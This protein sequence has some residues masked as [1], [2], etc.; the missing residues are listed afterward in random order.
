M[1][2][3][4]VSLMAIFFISA[5]TMSAQVIINEIM[6][7]PVRT[8]TDG[9]NNTDDSGEWIEF[10]NAG[11]SEVDMA[12]WSFT[13]GVEFTFPT[14]GSKIASGGYFILGRDS[15]QFNADNNFY[16]H[17]TWLT[18]GS[19]ALSNSGE[20]IRVVNASGVTVDSVD[21]DD[22]S[23]WP[24]EADGTGPSLELKDFAA[25]NAG[26][27]NSTGFWSISSNKGTPN[28]VNSNFNGT[29]WASTST[30]SGGPVRQHEAGSWAGNTLPAINSMDAA[31]TDKN[32]W[33]KFEWGVAGIFGTNDTLAGHYEVSQ[34][35]F[36]DSGYVNVSYVTDVKTEGSGSM[37][38]DVA[39]HGTEGWGGYAKLQHMHPDTAKGFY[40]WSKYDTVS[41]QY[42]MPEA[43]TPRNII[44]LR[45]NV[46]EYSNVTD[47]TYTPADG[48]AGKTLG[49]YYYSFTQPRLDAAKSG[50]VTVDI[51]LVEDPNN[52]DNKNGFNH[53]GWAG[54]AGN[55]TFDTDR[56]KGFAF[57]FSGNASDSSV[58]KA[59]VYIDNMTL[60]GR[61]TTPFV[62]FNGKA[63]PADLGSPFGWGDGA[64]S[65]ME[66]VTGAGATS[67]TNGIKWTLGGDGWS[68]T[69]AGWNINPNHNMIYE[70]M[71]DSVQFKYKT[72]KF[73]GTNIRLQYEAGSGKLVKEVAITADDAWHTVKLALKDFIYGD[74][75]SAGFDTTKVKVFQFVAQ[76]KGY[77]GETMMLTD[78]WTGSPAFDFVPPKIAENVDAIAGNYSNAVVWDDVPGE[79][80]EVYDIYASRKAITDTTVAQLLANK[81]IDVVALGIIEDTQNTYHDLTIPLSDRWSNYYYAVVVTDAA[82]NK[83]AIS[84]SAASTSNKSRGIPTISLTPP[85]S[86]AADG[87]IAEWVASG[88]TPLFMG[89]STNSHGTPKIINTVDDDADASVKLY[90]AADTE[91]LYVGVDVTD[92]TFHVGAG[93]WWEQD[94]MELF[95]GL[96]D[97]RGGKHG[98]AQ[99]GAEPDYKFAFLGDSAFVEFGTSTGL[100]GKSYV[101]Y[102]NSGV[103]GS[104][105]AVIEFSIRLDS[106]AKIN[107]DSI[108]VPTEGMRIA[109]E[110]TWHDNDGSGAEGNVAMSKLNNDNAW[111]TPA[112]WSHTYVGKKDGDILSTEDDLVA[113]EFALEANYPNP[114]NPTTTIEYSIG[115]S[116]VTKL[117]VYDILGREMV[118]LVDEFRPI[119]THKVIWNA[120][121]MPSG[122]YFYRLETSSFTRTQKMILMK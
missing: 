91:K 22:G 82:G 106:L 109:I 51:P 16:P 60:K 79:F 24:T 37:K 65:T 73:S 100:S 101:E 105:D 10:F 108:F 113:T 110:P 85:A 2:K 74:G 59:T 54:I 114:F 61:K 96:Y 119:G 6:Y 117:M 17:L 102:K 92:N 13:Q 99:R 48:D 86:F 57:E 21:Y 80:G 20:D 78:M 47:P 115:L 36:K 111:Q 120:S 118:R 52:W 95:I 98:A 69:G 94:A 90:L 26:G 39:V 63:S 68:A 53:T 87:D 66:S 49:E 33:Q 18:T 43:A 31:S 14:S 27:D 62:Y 28:V 71:K 12:G 77:Q 1:K 70:W 9:S 104:P 55:E 107:T 15:T 45:F 25:D 93:N 32:Y 34:N 4:L 112:V 46:L 88:I 75:T 8:N 42:H 122:V 11:Q 81:A 56:V 23:P 83:S 30:A 97:Q 44:E 103:N 38:L 89:V 64:A 19:G 76:G 5:P 121:S 3:T 35:S 29:A 41:F 7:N 58:A 40:D 67:A 72:A 116:G 84:A 50:W